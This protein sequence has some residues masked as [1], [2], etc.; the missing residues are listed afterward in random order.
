MD[1]MQKRSGV[2]VMQKMKTEMERKE[3]ATRQ[4]NIIN[5]IHNYISSSFFYFASSIVLL[6][7]A[8]VFVANDHCWSC[9]VGKVC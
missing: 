7:F 8:A 4:Q 2:P 9:N 5:K 6:K 1:G 3:S